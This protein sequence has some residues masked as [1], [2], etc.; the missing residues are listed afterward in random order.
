MKV[1]DKVNRDYP[2]AYLTMNAKLH[3]GVTTMTGFRWYNKFTSNKELFH[4]LLCSFHV[5]F[6]CSYNA[7]IDDM[8]CIDGGFG[9]NVDVDLPDDCF[10]ICPKVYT[11]K[12]KNYAYINGEMP[13]LFCVFPPMPAIIDY[14]YNKGK[15]DMIAYKVSKKSHC[16]RLYS[17]DE[18]HIPI[19]L[20]FL[21]RALQPEDTKN[22]LSNIT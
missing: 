8:N 18:E 3:I 22:V 20:W 13:I 17:I 15:N 6:L 4:I 14:Y 12:L 21:L 16:L 11:T 5:P 9:I 10:I 7:K 1:F 19:N 2:N